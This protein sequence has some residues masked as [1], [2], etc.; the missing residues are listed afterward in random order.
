MQ[1][2]TSIV[3]ALQYITITRPEISF[4]VNKVCQ[5]MQAPFEVTGKQS[6]E[7]SDIQGK[8]TYGLH[9]RKSYYLNLVGHCDADWIAN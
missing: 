6:K 1:F 2:Y 4:S 7:F 8:L 9:L 3:G 5:F